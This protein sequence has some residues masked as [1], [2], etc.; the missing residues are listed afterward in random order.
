MRHGILSKVGTVCKAKKNKFPLHN[1]SDFC[2]YVINLCFSLALQQM[3]VGGEHAAILASILELPEGS[4]WNWNFHTLEK[5]THDAIEEVELA[6]QQTAV[7]TE[8]LET[9]NDDSC[10]T[11]QN[12]LEDV[13]PLHRIEASFDM[14]WQVRYSGIKFGS[15]T[16]HAS[17]IGAMSKK[18]LDSIVYNKNC[19]AWIKHMS[20][21]VSYIG[22]KNHYCLKNFVGTSKSM[23]AL[24]LVQMLNRAF[25]LSSISVCT[26]I[27]D[28]DRNGRGK[29]SM[30]VMVEN[31][32][33]MWKSQFF[34]LIRHITNKCWHGQYIYFGLRSNEGQ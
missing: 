14:G 20:L 5:N 23:E 13:I 15:P 24:A 25:E 27:S 11:E 16:G 12:K 7:E 9:V 21:T 19:T 3:A 34:W 28:D 4:K 29:H 1:K 33:K 6:S 8:V 30:L 17:L 22:V 26:I 18:V 10:N 31:Y 32:R 2:Q